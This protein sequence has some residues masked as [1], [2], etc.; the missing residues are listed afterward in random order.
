[1]K[2]FTL[3]F[4]LVIMLVFSS[5]MLSAHVI[6]GKSFRSD[7][8]V[9]INEIMASNA[10]IIAD[11]DG[12]FEDW[13]EI[14]NFGS[15]SIQL[16]GWG[17]SDESSNP[18]RFVFPSTILEPGEYLL[19][20]CSKKDRAISGQ[21]LHTDYGISASGEEI[22]LTHPNGD[23]VDLVPATPLVADISWGRY[24]DATGPWFFFDQPTPLEPNASEYYTEI[25][26]SPIFSLPGGFYTEAFELSI[27]HP[28][29]DVTI[30]YTLDGS[31]PDIHNLDGK[32]YQYKNSFPRYPENPYG[33]ML[34]NTYHTLIY[35]EPLN[36][37]DRSMNDDYLSQISS[38]WDFIP[39]YLPESPS[40]KATVIR[41]KAFKPQALSSPTLSNSYFVF[42]QGSARYSLPVVSVQIQENYLFDYY[43]GTYTA[44]SDFDL[45]RQTYPN[46]ETTD[47]KPAN[48]RRKGDGWEYPGNVEFFYP[49]HATAVINQRIGTRIHGGGSAAKRLK[50]LRLYARDVYGKSDFDYRF[51]PEQPYSS[52]KRLILRNSG[53][54]YDRT[55]VHD[56]SIHEVMK[57]LNFDTQAYSP[58]ITF[59]NGE[60]WGLLNL[61]ERFDK[62]Y[63]ARVYGADKENLDL[64]E[65][66]VV[67]D[68]GDLIQYDAMIDYI[69]NHDLSTAANYEQL[70]T[71]MDI[72]NFLDYYIAE[73]YINNTDWPQNNVK[74]WRLRT[75]C[76]QAD[77]PL[78]QDG[79]FRWLFYDTDVGF[80]PEANINANTLQRVYTH[81]CTTSQ[82]F[83]ALLDNERAKNR[84]ITRFSDLL[85]SAF[86]PAR[87]DSIIDKNIQRISAEV[88][89]H[90]Q[91]WQMPPSMDVWDAKID[92]MHSFANLRPAFQREHL[93]EFFDL[94]SDV[95]IALQ[96]EKIE[97]GN[98]KINTI[99]LPSEEQEAGPLSWTGTYF[100][101]MPLRL[102]A[103]P[104]PGYMFSHWEGDLESDDA[105]LN[106]TPTHDLNLSAVFEIDPNAW[107]QIIHYWHFNDLPSGTLESVEADFSANTPAL[108]TYPGSGDGYM[109]KRTH[110]AADPVSNLNLLMDQE[111][112]QG[113]VLRARNPSDTRDLVVQAPSTGFTDIFG[114]YA[115][116]RTSNGATLQEM[117]YSTDGGENW[118]LL[119][120]AYLVPEIPDWSLKSFDL[121]GIAAADHNPELMFKFR[122][123]GDEAANDSGNDRFDNFSIHGSLILNDAPQVVFNPEYLYGIE[124]GE[125]LN[126]DC[127]EYFS[128]PDL[129][130]L[131]FSVQSSRSGFAELNIS[132]NILEINPIKRGDTC[133]SIFADD[134][135]NP[136]V[137][138]SFQL[139]IYPQAFELSKADFCFDEW[140]E[141]TAELQYPE[142][143]L[144]LQSDTD[145][146]DEDYPLNYVYYIAED[147]YHADDSESIG[148]PYQLTGR[149]RLNGLN[150]DGISFINTGRGRDL[151]AALIALNTEAVDA[152][153]LSWLAATLLQNNREYGLKVQYRVGIEDEFQ[154]L[155]PWQS[156]QVG[157]DGEVQ[158]FLPFALPTELLNQEYVQLLFR[159][160][161]IT[162]SSGKRAEL[163]LDDIRINTSA[164]DD[165]PLKMAYIALKNTEEN[166]VLLTWQ[167]RVESDLK[168]F[169]V[170]RNTVDDFSLADRISNHIPAAQE[171]KSSQYQF[172]DAQLYHDG[173]YYY[174]VEAILNSGPK[175]LF[176]PY[177]HFWDSSLSEEPTPIPSSTSLGN[178]YP[179]PFKDLLYIPYSLA[180]DG[181]VSVDIYNLRGQKVS[182]MDIGQK[183]SGTH[184]AT[185][186]AQDSNSKA[187]SSGIYIIKLKTK[188][189]SY[190]KKAMLIK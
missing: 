4:V 153:S 137:K 186:K 3:Q 168:S 35:D 115:I 178:L 176:G 118:H 105:I 90:I 83:A 26:A 40:S 62:H 174:W 47:I 65:N 23:L 126:L 101:S 187:L 103:L 11:E 77:A 55:L 98:I 96:S 8:D 141:S 111:P 190:V 161:H 72:D 135:F 106:L 84:F 182:S 45:W 37:H 79:R 14:L 91:R 124:N 154:L 155:D 134:G 175:K 100:A 151:G 49:E 22:M 74:C 123:L 89:E 75:D 50:S 53:Q 73:I 64:I 180:K 127:S 69:Q 5:G 18:F 133:I 167:S 108:I 125:S 99:K 21:P 67:A 116:S 128:D 147:D 185:W 57:D 20:W 142:N 13:V 51:F 33:E 29:P 102:E 31:E 32:T 24:P 82:I 92:M 158:H 61:R 10:S 38:T 1:M 12:D 46:D 130:E 144:F 148:F 48:W 132:D 7:Y 78:G 131:S 117:Y 162:G 87:I 70:S 97:R 95:Q 9:C 107:V 104:K 164:E 41:A 28:D 59:L 119:K 159:Y 93:R 112:D 122:F 163:R 150:Q 183:A 188:G 169:L 157:T 149:S 166:Q 121:K 152:A 43:D 179:N 140:D 129:D 6:P 39:D 170:Y 120:E 34:Y 16:E 94:G 189:K 81:S 42:A 85:N 30:L 110:R 52:Y 66:G 184:C 114:A 113:A 36:I 58:V 76:Y 68:Y 17:L 86:I 27:S 109:D 25:L 63:L 56:A 54:D 15:E 165:F 44:G 2:R 139:L 143:M 71:L 88:P 171:G 177:S 80:R 146:P 136:P 19:V 156:Y 181:L 60:Y 138:L 172:I 160:H 173:E 145:D